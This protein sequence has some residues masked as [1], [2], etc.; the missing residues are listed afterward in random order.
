MDEAPLAARYFL[1]AVFCLAGLAKLRSPAIATSVATYDLL[2]TRAVHVV[3]RWL[4]RVEVT[5]AP[6]C[7]PR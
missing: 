2:S 4:P 5:V 7:C 1:G 3:A 6:C